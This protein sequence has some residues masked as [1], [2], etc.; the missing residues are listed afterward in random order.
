MKEVLLI[1]LKVIGIIFYLFVALVIGV[2]FSPIAGWVMAIAG[3]VFWVIR[4]YKKKHS[5]SLSD[6]F[7][8]HPRLLKK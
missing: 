6:R 4:H 1:V 7:R 5:P 8:H 3:I 2:G